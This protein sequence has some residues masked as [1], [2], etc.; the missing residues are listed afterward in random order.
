M[1]ENG[2]ILVRFAPEGLDRYRCV[3]LP[4]AEKPLPITYCYCCGG[5][6]KHHLQIALGRNLDCTVLSSALSS[7]GQRPCKFS[8]RTTD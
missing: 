1:G 4:K 6:V 7:A 5:H 3:C 2:E 8:F